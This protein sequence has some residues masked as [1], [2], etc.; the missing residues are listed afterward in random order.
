MYR[1]FI[2]FVHINSVSNSLLIECCFY[3]SKIF[4]L[5]CITNK[6]IW[7][8]SSAV[9]FVVEVNTGGTGFYFLNL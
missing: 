3:F 6:A 9:T 4:H 1:P 7:P 5:Y 8:V 2:S